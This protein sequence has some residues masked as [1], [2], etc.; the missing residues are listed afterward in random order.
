MKEI[1]AALR[2]LG[3]EAVS[4]NDGGFLPIRIKGAQLRGKA[5]DLPI[6]SAHLKSV[7]LLGALQAKGMTSLAESLPTR[8]HAERALAFTE[9]ELMLHNGAIF[10]AGGQTPR[11]FDFTIPGDI[12]SGAFWLALAAPVEGS[13]LILRNV[14][15]N[16]HC[17]GFVDALVHMGAAV[18]EEVLACDE[19]EWYGHLDIR[20]G[21]LKPFQ[22]TGATVPFLIDEIPILAVMA[23]KAEGVSTIR[24]AAHLRNMEIDR[25][26]ATASNLK[27]MGVEVE[28]F[29]DGMT[30]YGTGKLQGA[31]LDSVGDHRI[32]M[33]FAIAGL[34]GEGDSIIRQAE[35]IPVS[36]PEF[37]VDLDRLIESTNR[38]LAAV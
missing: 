37:L 29:S 25:I 4:L 30:I 35:C 23:A 8:D 28:E 16:Q 17:L 5:F 2:E 22:V 3:A 7:I 15:L 11:R 32:A 10:L 38:E 20:G 31:D 14:S 19:H 34:L 13:R 26:A 6:A 36:Y 9:V 18:R 27:R 1:K 12:S 33:A 21:C 24:G